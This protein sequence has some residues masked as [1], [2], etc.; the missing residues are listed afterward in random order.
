MLKNSWQ[1]WT[2]LNRLSREMDQLFGPRRRGAASSIGIGTFPAMN[3]W[4]DENN[5]YVEAELP[6]FRNDEI[7]IHVTGKQMT[8]KGERQPPHDKD[9]G[10]EDGRWHRRERGFGEFT[11][12]IELS[13]RVDADAVS[14]D[15]NLGVLKVT[16]PKSEAVKPRRIEV[17]A[18]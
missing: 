15:L 10:C 1:P 4:E 3:L 16:L 7:E 5:L 8:V 9:G 11:R 14:A 17:K 2:E 18:G 12:V 6:G 13:G